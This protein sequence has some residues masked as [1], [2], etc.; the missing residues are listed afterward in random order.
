MFNKE[1]PT[2]ERINA[3]ATLI[4]QGTTLKGDVSS[5]TDLRIDGTIHGNISCTAKIIIGPTGF[6]EGNIDGQQADITG[7]VHGNIT[8]QDMLQLRGDCNVQGNISSGKLQIEPTAIFNGKCQMGS[9]ANIV[10]M[11][12][13]ELQAEAQ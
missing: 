13:N 6:I 5:D 12:S 11:S 10:Q 1:K 8:V 9:V 2:N 7:K 4:S 3:S